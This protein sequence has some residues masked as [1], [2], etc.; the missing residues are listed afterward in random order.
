MN[1][2]L[3]C[4]AIFALVLL[5]G[6]L[7]FV[8]RFASEA[9]MLYR[10][11]ALAAGFLICA[12]LLVALPEGLEHYLHAAE[13]AEHRAFMWAGLTVL[14]GFLFMLILEG[15]GFGHDFHEEHHGHEAEFGHPHLHHPPTGS[16][17]AV[18]IG[19]GLHSVTDGL[20]LGAAFA[21]G[22]VSLSMQLA[23]VILMHKFPAAFSLAAF[24]LHSRRSRSRSALD[25]L[26]FALLTP[27]AMLIA[28]QFLADLNHATLGLML[29]F[30]AGSFVY[31][32]TVDVL[33]NIHV[34]AKSHETL[35]LVLGGVAIMTALV[36]AI[37]PAH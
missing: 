24:S 12:A 16:A 8:H 19:L 4:A 32:A 14:A 28:V 7:P 25:L 22:G 6:A 30:G 31:V 35:W 5:A 37:G 3:F 34:R 15:F 11:T 23:T 10:A 29:L 33:P 13:V 36:L 27:A 21:L 17:R 20:V 9:Q 26:L 2:G 18:A 1:L